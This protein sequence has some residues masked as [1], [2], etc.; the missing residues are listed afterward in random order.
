MIA[1]SL[2]TR[3]EK[4]AT[5]NGFDLRLSFE[6]D[7]L[8]FASS[9]TPLRLWMSVDAEKQLLVAFSQ[10]NIADELPQHQLVMPMFLPPGAKAA[11]RAPD[12]PAFDRLVRRV[13]QLS[14][15]LPDELWHSF[16]RQTANL[17]Q[18]TEVE[19]LVVQRVGQDLFRAA[20]LDYWRGR[21]AISGL[22]VRELLRASHIKPWADCETD[23]ER[24]D[25]HNG[26]LLAP[27]FDA[28]F[29]LGFITIEDNG[30][31]VVSEVL[32]L[33]A[34]QCLHL[35]KPLHILG[36][37]ERHGRY[38]PWHRAKVFK[39]PREPRSI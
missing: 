8:A 17:P 9:Q 27:H 18:S 2:R 31:V 22:A 39:Q 16:Q 15:T 30:E 21:C 7:W 5:D 38:L 36:L 32:P 4:I 24:L 3:L 33:E 19:R 1:P 12:M 37:H 14:L 34:R 10:T 28:A 13:F 26:I 35:D 25:V 6:N 11:L 20:L 29:D 23:A